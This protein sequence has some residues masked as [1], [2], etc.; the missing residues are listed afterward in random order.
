MNG[1]EKRVK[2]GV[3]GTGKKRLETRR[4]EKHERQERLLWNCFFFGLKL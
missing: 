3:K 1:I 2:V 4:W